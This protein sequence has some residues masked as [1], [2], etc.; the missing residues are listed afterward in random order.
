MKLLTHLPNLLVFLT[1]SFSEI[2]AQ[3]PSLEF[4]D[5]VC[6]G[7]PPVHY[8]SRDKDLVAVM[9]YVETGGDTLVLQERLDND[10]ILGNRTLTGDTLVYVERV[11]PLDLSDG[12]DNPSITYELFN[13]GVSV[14][15][16]I[17]L[18]S[19]SPWR[20]GID[21][22]YYAVDSIASSAT[23]LV[24]TAEIPDT[25]ELPYAAGGRGCPEHHLLITLEGIDIGGAIGTDTVDLSAGE[26][27]V[28]N[29]PHNGNPGGVCATAEVI[30]EDLGQWVNDFITTAVFIAEH[31]TNV[32]YE[33]LLSTSI[34]ETAPKELAAWPNPCTDKLSVSGLTP[35]K[36]YTVY[37]V[38]KKIVDKGLVSGAL[39][40][41]TESWTPGIYMLIS[42]QSP[43]L[44]IARQ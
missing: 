36:E 35:G 22:L 31:T 42:E 11:I 6:D 19:I 1:L 16:P 40:L 7:I 9:I 15:Q 37:N 21:T 28:F 41:N 8:I 33:Y 26:P 39:E 29:I 27:L 5:F 23:E 25:Y 32:C 34:S 43:P 4:V 10:S 17:Y 2:Q 13:D 24:V 30:H 44:K 14:A 12:L 20:D 3:A 38:D 18:G